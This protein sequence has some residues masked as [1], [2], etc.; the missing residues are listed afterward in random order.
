VL[1]TF[2]LYLLLLAVVPV[3]SVVAVMGLAL[4]I[5]RTTR[6]WAKRFLLWTICGSGGAFVGVI[7]LGLTALVL[8]QLCALI[9]RTTAGASAPEDSPVLQAAVIASIFAPFLGAALGVVLGVGVGNRIA[10]GLSVR[11]SLAKI[12]PIA[13]LMRLVR[14]YEVSAV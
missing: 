12:R 4:A 10:A 3:L 1:P 7:L 6:P 5:S 9:V 2:L 14:V 8:L 11:Q 13:A